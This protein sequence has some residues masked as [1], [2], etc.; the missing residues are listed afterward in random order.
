[1][2]TSCFFF[3]GTF[4]VQGCGHTVPRKGSKQETS[5]AD[6]DPDFVNLKAYIIGGPLGRKII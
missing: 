2:K 5:L 6:E 3:S 4:W 1:M